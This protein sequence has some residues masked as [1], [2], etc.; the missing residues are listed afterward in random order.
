MGLEPSTMIL[1]TLMFGLLVWATAWA[2]DWVVDKLDA[3]AHR[4]G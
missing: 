2:V 4:R 3:G 1:H